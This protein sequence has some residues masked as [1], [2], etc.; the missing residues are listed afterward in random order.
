MAPHWAFLPCGPGGPG[1]APKGREEAREGHLGAHLGSVAGRPCGSPPRLEA[2][3]ADRL[4]LAPFNLPGPGYASSTG[5]LP[6]GLPPGLPP[7]AGPDPPRR[8]S[9]SGR[10]T[11][12][13]GAAE[14][15]NE[16]YNA[17]MQKGGGRGASAGDV[18]ANQR[19]ELARLERRAVD[20]SPAVVSLAAA[21][22]AGL[23]PSAAGGAKV[24]S[25]SNGP[26]PY[27]ARPL[28]GK[29][30]P[31]RD[32]YGKII[33]E[34]VMAKGMQR[35]AELDQLSGGKSGS[36]KASFSR[37]ASQSPSRSRA[38]SASRC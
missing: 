16:R 22:A 30:G 31:L 14:D 17:Q 7:G 3:P 2:V 4:R 12:K 26:S 11:G 27:Y 29:E 23:D 33:K 8:Q 18:Y 6:A 36:R 25:T 13:A 35:K 10:W 34:D 21:S 28:Q 5:S 15:A 38:G 37:K 32:G 19:G 20:S 9:S 24:Y 1:A